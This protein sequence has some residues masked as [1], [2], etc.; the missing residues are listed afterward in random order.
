[1]ISSWVSVYP[2]VVSPT[3]ASV[4]WPYIKSHTLTWHF[5]HTLH[6][7][8]WYFL[9]KFYNSGNFSNLVNTRVCSR[10]SVDSRQHA[11]NNGISASVSCSIISVS[12]HQNLSWTLV[13]FV[14][15]T[16]YPTSNVVRSRGLQFPNHNP[17]SSP[18]YNISRIGLLVS[19]I[20]NSSYISHS[21]PPKFQ[22]K[23][24]KNV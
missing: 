21:I 23:S 14:W 12:I 17:T 10:Q 1:M 8:T 2:S 13:L 22:S 3:M 7:Y 19:Y 6:T 15:T 4:N 20:V 11:Q 9:Q 18:Q 5:L 24:K 16:H